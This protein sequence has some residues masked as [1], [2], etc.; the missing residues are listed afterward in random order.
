[1]TKTQIQAHRGASYLAP[2]N[3]F[4]SFRLALEENADWIELDIHQSAD[5]H[6]VVM[7]DET[8]SRTSNGS[9]FIKSKTREEL[10]NLDCGSWFSEEFKGEK[11]PFLEEVLIWGKQ[12]QMKFNIE[13][14][15]GSRFYHGIEENLLSLLAQTEMTSQVLISSFDHYALH[16]LRQLHSE[17]K[18]GML[19]TASLFEPWNYAKKIGV[20]AL[21]PY[22]V[23]VD[24]ILLRGA[25]EHG[26]LLNPYTVDDEA[27]MVKLLEAG[28]NSI[29]TNKPKLL[30]S[31]RENSL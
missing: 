8:L 25:S 27:A 10:S 20:Q 24:P 19:Y 18:T 28:V 13:L 1:M 29:I 3:T 2:E 12:H 15:A 6:L 21:H 11:I 14:K 9:G 7:H 23:T 5:G 22:F 30:Y 17:V 4:S 31:L 26:L 16:F